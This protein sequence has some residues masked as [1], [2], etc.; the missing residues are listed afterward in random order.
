MARQAD[1]S[2]LEQ[3]VSVGLGLLSLRGLLNLT[4]SS[5]VWFCLWGLGFLWF[6]LSRMGCVH[7]FEQ[8]VGGAPSSLSQLLQRRIYLFSSL[9]QPRRQ[10]TWQLVPNL[11]VCWSLPKK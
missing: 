5:E 2:P 8:I 9:V 11:R 4:H 7:T 3:T 1:F 10:R 6:A